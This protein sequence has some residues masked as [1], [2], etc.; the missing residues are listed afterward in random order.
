MISALAII[1]F[2][3]FAVGCGQSN[4]R[5]ALPAGAT[6]VH[7]YYY[8]GGNGDFTRCFS[9]TMSPTEFDQFV[10]QLELK[11]KYQSSLHASLPVSFYVNCSKPWWTPPDD[12]IEGS[13]F[14]DFPESDMYEVV[15]YRDGIAYYVATSW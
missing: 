9:A 14:N 6:N 4:V 15:G 5:Q 11:T 8:G 12:L 3:V 7:E 10:Q 2:A 13:Y 1:F